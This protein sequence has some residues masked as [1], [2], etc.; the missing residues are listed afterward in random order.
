MPLKENNQMRPGSHFRQS[1]KGILTVII[2]ICAVGCATNI[3][4]EDLLKQLQSDAP[5]LVVD[6]RSQGEYDRDH[7]PGAVHI[8]FYSIGSGLKELGYPKFNPVVLYCEHGPRTG[9]AGFSLY[10][11]GYKKVYSLE[12]NMKGW[13]KNEFPI[14]IITH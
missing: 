10:L 14:E 11:S 13:R 9:I 4:R 8:P 6:V 3:T 12:G 2:V 7:V 1:I 5:P